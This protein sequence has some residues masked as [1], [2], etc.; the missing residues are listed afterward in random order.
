VI[1]DEEFTEK[2]AAITF[3]GD[4]GAD[5]AVVHIAD[6]TGDFIRLEVQPFTAE[7]KIARASDE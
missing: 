6:D 2:Q 1:G 5:P 4:G 7:V 3:A